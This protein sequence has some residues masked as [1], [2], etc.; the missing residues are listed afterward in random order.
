MKRVFLYLCILLG[1]CSIHAIPDS[2]ECEILLRK[3]TDSLLAHSGDSVLYKQVRDT[4]T[5]WTQIEMDTS[6]RQ[7]KVNVK[8]SNCPALDSTVCKA[9]SQSIPPCFI[10]TYGNEVYM[11]QGVIRIIYCFRPNRR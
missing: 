1:I 8:K 10:A 11:Y 3:L 7:A 5:V 9:F 2:P 6:T 4:L